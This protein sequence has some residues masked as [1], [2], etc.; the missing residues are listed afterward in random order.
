MY[1]HFK[2]F[3][4]SYRTPAMQ[5]AQAVSE[6]HGPWIRFVAVCLETIKAAEWEVFLCHAGEDKDAVARP[7]AQSLDAS[8]I[9]CWFDEI[10]VGWGESIGEK[11]QEGL[12]RSRYTIV[13]VSSSLSKKRWARRELRT[14]LALEIDAGSTTVLPLIVG[15]PEALLGQFP[16]LREKRYLLW[17]GE[18]APVVQELRRLE[19]RNG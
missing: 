11:I 19:R 2:R 17:S 14:A 8:G 4:S 9:R 18:S 1:D 5:L 15:Q 13:I 3:Q 6:A 10:E 7:L 16:F 12:S